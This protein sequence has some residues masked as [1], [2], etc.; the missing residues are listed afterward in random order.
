MRN[1]RFIYKEILEFTGEI[2]VNQINGVFG[3]IL[4]ILIPFLCVPVFCS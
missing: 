4:V 1:N 2:Q 3:K